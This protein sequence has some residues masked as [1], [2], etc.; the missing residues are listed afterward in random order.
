MI[1]VPMVPKL[2][3]MLLLETEM[4]SPFK[5]SP[6][7]GRPNSYWARMSF[8][9]LSPEESGAVLIAVFMIEV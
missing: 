2:T 8:M 7:L 1:P 3:K 6:F 5:T 9:E 4:T